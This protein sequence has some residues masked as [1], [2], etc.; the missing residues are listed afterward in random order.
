VLSV[1]IHLMNK[2]AQLPSTEDQSL[3]WWWDTRLFL[4]FLLDTCDLN[5][6]IPMSA[7]VARRGK[8]GEG[9]HLVFGIDIQFDLNIHAAVSRDTLDRQ[10]RFVYL[11]AC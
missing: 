10:N 7:T 2:H 9:S 1:E 11:L 8:G 5:M 6:R 3:L 4:D